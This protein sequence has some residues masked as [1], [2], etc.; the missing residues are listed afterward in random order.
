MGRCQ[1][2]GTHL[3]YLTCLRGKAYTI[4]R[5]KQIG[6]KKPKPPGF[7]SFSSR[8]SSQLLWA[9]TL[10]SHTKPI[11]QRTTKTSFTAISS[12]YRSSSLGTRAYALNFQSSKLPPH[13]SHSVTPSLGSYPPPRSL[14]QHTPKSSP[15]CPDPLPLKASTSRFQPRL[16]TLVSTH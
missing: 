11:P 2:E 10:S 13:C 12:A 7:Y 3:I 15:P 5:A 9:S 14:H 4:S 8:S 1:C 16:R 6:R